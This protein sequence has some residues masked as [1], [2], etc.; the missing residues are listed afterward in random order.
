MM[1]Q[2]AMVRMAI[3]RIRERAGV[4]EDAAIREGLCPVG[5]DTQMGLSCYRRRDGDSSKIKNR[6]TV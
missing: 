2:L 6:S 1:H 5:G 3:I 4:A